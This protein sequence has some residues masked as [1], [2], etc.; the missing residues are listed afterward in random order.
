MDA[1]QRAAHLAF[2]YEGEVQNGG[3][4]QCFE[5]LR[6]DRL[7]ETVAAL[8]TMGATEYQRILREAIQQFHSQPR[9]FLLSVEEFC[10]EASKGEFQTL[11]TQFYECKPDLA[12][13]LGQF[14]NDHQDSFVIIE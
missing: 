2:L 13:Y 3:H 12:H 11:D 8:G 14:L 10:E 5:N 1:I 4:L 9:P 6:E 7:K